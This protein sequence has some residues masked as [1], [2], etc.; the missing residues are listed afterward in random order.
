MPKYLFV[1]REI[2]KHV[3]AMCNYKFDMEHGIAVV[4][5]N[6]MFSKIVSQDIIL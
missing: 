6:E 5:E 2:N 3:V 1:K 4:F